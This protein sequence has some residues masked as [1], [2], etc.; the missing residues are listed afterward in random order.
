MASGFIVMQYRGTATKGC[1]EVPHPQIFSLLA[2]LL[3]FVPDATQSCHTAKSCKYEP[4][5]NANIQS[6]FF[7]AF[8]LDPFLRTGILITG[9]TSRQKNMNRLISQL[10]ILMCEY[11][12]WCQ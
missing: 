6:L 9:A 10:S 5:F 12:S 7:L 8:V 1:G 2:Q 11:L 4:L 3:S